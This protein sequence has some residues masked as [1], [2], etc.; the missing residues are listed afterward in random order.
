MPGT[1][2]VDCELC[3][4]AL[5]AVDRDRAAMLLRDN[6]ITDREPEPR[7]L[8][9]RLRRE[10]RL[11]QLVAKFGCNPNTIVAHPDLDRVAKILCRHLQ[12]RAKA[13]ARLAPAL[14][15]GIKAIAEQVEEHPC[16]VLRHHLDRSDNAIELPLQGDVEALILGARAMLGEVERLLDESV[17]VRR[18]PI[19]AP[20]ARMRQHVLDD[21]VGAAA[22]L[23]VR[24]EKAALSSG[25]EAHPALRSSRKQSEQS[26]R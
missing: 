16:D 24:R 12:R 18:L 5:S 15:G 4:V 17:D 21:A 2:Q 6:V 26:W 9:S 14:V 22:V 13:V 11:E 25:C 10:E 3:K 7:T 20:A 19:A 23:G 8:A 1:R